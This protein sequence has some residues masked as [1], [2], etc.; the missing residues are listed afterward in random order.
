MTLFGDRKFF[1]KKMATNISGSHPGLEKRE[2]IGNNKRIT[3]EENRKHTLLIGN[4]NKIDVKR[5]SGI[6]EIVG[7]STHV[8]IG[9][10]TGRVNYIGNNGKLFIGNGCDTNNIQYIGSNGAMEFISS[11]ENK[12]EKTCKV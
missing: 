12:S 1:G 8:K 6:L 10:N 5:N 7:N 4:A 3:I 2:Y 11:K 9:E